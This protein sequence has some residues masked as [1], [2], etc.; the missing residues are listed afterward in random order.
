MNGPLGNSEFYFPRISLFPETL[1]FSG[2]KIYCSPQDQSLSVYYSPRA[3]Y[4]KTI[5]HLSVDG[6]G[7][8]LPRLFAATTNHLF[9]GE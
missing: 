7:E 6:S 1:R 4:T 2:N 5:I 3:V 9:F 8:Y